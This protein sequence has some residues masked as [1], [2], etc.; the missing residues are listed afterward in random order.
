MIAKIKLV[1][2][3]LL[4]KNFV[5]KKLDGY[6]SQVAGVLIGIAFALDSIAV[7]L[8]A[9]IQLHVIAISTA[10]KSIAGALGFVGAVGKVAKGR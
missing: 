8:P 2:D 10:L 1:L 9:E 4:N 5:L 3:Y 6:K 7:F